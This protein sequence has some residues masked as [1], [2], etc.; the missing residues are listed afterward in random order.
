MIGTYGF[1]IG[2]YHADSQKACPVNEQI[3]RRYKQAGGFGLFS[4]V[5][6]GKVHVI[7]AS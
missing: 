7:A 4:F 2:R 6:N 5:V 1:S 3:A